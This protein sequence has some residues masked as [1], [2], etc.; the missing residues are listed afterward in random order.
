MSTIPVMS[1]L[2]F[3]TTLNVLGNYGTCQLED[4]Q[5]KGSCVLLEE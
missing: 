1:G 2:R 5:K 3:A 4:I